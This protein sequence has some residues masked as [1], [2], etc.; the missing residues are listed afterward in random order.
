MI[1]TTRAILAKAGFSVS[2]AIDIRGICFDIVGRREDTLLIIKV[3]GNVDAFTR[4]N[5]KEMEI[6]AE[7]LGASPLIIGES[8]SSGP[9]ERGIVYTRL[10]VPILS[11]ETLADKLLEDVP[12]FIF[13]APGGLYVNLDGDLLSRYRQETGTSLGA[14]A[15]AAGVSR[16]TIQMY[17]EG[18]SA[19]IDAALCLEEFTGIQLI[20][21]VNPF[22]YVP[23]RDPDREMS[24]S[25]AK[26]GSEQLNHMALI[27]FAVTPMSR[28][29]VEAVSRDVDADIVLLTGLGSKKEQIMKKAH[30]AS[31]LSDL[32]GKRSVLIVKTSHGLERIDSTALVSE[33]ELKKFDDKDDFND[34]VAARSTKR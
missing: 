33:E 16:R 8:S 9:L 17:E 20:E 30:I 29:P 10:M 11:N 1:N 15:E 2:S 31:E 34:L 25:N 26:T 12:P 7:A 6:L 28:G 21:P 23:E 18:M 4:Q 13:A 32:S 22:G 24:G 19:M 5:A 14:L 3:L 27:G